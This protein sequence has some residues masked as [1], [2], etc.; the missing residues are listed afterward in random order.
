MEWKNKKNK[1]KNLEDKNMI[2][3]FKTKINTVDC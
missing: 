1:K 3:K 2:T